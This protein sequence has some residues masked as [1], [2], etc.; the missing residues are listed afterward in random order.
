MV[1]GVVLAPVLAAALAMMVT[2]NATVAA[3]AFFAVV[4][5]AVLAIAGSVRR[6]QP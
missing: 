2:G 3:V 4:A 1:K 6:R 5:C